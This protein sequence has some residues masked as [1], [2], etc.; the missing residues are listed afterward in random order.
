MFRPGSNYNGSTVYPVMDPYTFLVTVGFRYAHPRARPP[1]VLERMPLPALAEELRAGTKNNP[2]LAGF[3]YS[4]GLITITYDEGVTRYK[5]KMAT[6]IISMGR[7]WGGGW[8]NQRAILVRAPVAE[9]DSLAPVFSIIHSSVKINLQWLACEIREQISRSNKAL[10]IQQDIQRIERETVE[11]RQRSNAEI[12]NDMYLTLTG[13]ED[14]INPHTHEVERGSNE[15]KYRWV[16]PSGE[17]VYSNNDSYDPKLDPNDRRTD[18]KRSE[19]RP[20]PQ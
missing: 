9:F 16:S 1:Q 4:A 14:Y 2:V 13:Q 12:N 8:G 15:W 5:E 3:Q 6:G 11:H 7:Q 17:E 10:Q 18:F 19:V 20:R